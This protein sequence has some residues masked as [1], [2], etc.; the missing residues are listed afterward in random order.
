MKFGQTTS[1]TAGQIQKFPARPCL[2]YT[3]KMRSISVCPNS[4]P[5]QKSSPRLD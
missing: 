1:S 3:E 2:I 4:D 5:V